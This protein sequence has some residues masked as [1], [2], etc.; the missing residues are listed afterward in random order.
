MFSLYIKSRLLKE[1]TKEI[2]FNLVFYKV[3]SIFIKIYNKILVN[4]NSFIII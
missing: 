4:I 1:I 2:L 3:Y